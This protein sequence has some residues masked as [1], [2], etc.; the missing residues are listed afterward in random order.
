[1]E[2][3]IRRPPPNGVYVTLRHALAAHRGAA[4]VPRTRAGRLLFADTVPLGLALV[5]GAGRPPFA[6]SVPIGM[7]LAE[8]MVPREVERLGDC[9]TAII[10][11]G[12]RT[13]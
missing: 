13:R 3:S 6:D 4:L 5:A 1:M 10:R 9:V 12:R 11:S 7:A 2:L 8:F